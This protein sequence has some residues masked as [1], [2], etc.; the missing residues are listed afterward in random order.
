M[1]LLGSALGF[2]ALG[3]AVAMGQPLWLAVMLHMATGTGLVLMWGLALTVRAR[4]LRRG[5]RPRTLP[6]AVPLAG[7]VAGPIRALPR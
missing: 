4:V 6:V 1:I 5:L 2:V 7:P 3:A